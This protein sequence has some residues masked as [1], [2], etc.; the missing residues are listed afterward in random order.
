MFS[1]LLRKSSQVSKRSKSLPSRF[2]MEMLE[3]RQMMAGDV[4]ASVVNGNLYISEALGQTGLDNGVRVFQV[5]PGVV[6]VMGAENNGDGSTSLVNGQ[7]FQDFMITGDL[8]VNLGGGHDRLHLGFDG[9]SSAPNFNNVN[10]NM[11]APPLV[12]AQKTDL[13][14]GSLDTIYNGPDDDQVFGW[15]FNARGVVNVNTGIGN[16][17]VFISNSN[18]GDGLGVDKLTINTG[19]GSDTASIKGTTLLGNLLV[20]TYANAAENDADVIWIDGA[21]DSSFNTRATYITGNTELYTGG[22]DD[23]VMFGDSLDPYFTGLGF[24]TLGSVHLSTGN[25]ADTVDVSA[26]KF[27]DANHWSNLQ[28][29]TGSGNDDV[30]ITFDSSLIDIGDPWPELTGSLFISTSGAD[31]D[32]DTVNVSVAQIWNSFYLYMGIGDDQF[33][34]TGGNWGKYVTIDAG[35]GNDTGYFAGFLHENAEIRMGDG[36]DNLTLGHVNADQLKVDGGAGTDSLR[37][38]QPLAVDYLFQTGWE[39]INGRPQWVLGNVYD[40]Q[41]AT[42]AQ[43]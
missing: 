42:L 43:R 16:D 26:S 19:A 1:K 24:M 25:G 29:Y 9:G 21:L 12:I 13:T 20:Q 35:A 10:I 40:V 38:L 41:T 33:N 8:N 30:T 17:W 6:R 23:F 36:N 22:G 15:G 27:G 39:Y 14:K 34:L 18:I 37:K 11:G 3:N 31:S 32:N 2:R 7:Q 4:A 28:I 5:S